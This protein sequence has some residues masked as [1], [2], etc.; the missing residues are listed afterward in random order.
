MCKLLI[1]FLAFSPRLKELLAIFVISAGGTWVAAANMRRFWHAEMVEIE[2]RFDLNA[3]S[4]R[5]TAQCHKNDRFSGQIFL[6]GLKTRVPSRI[7][8]TVGQWLW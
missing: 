6:T 8:A 4:I 5:Y 1:I 3:S 2:Q 7:V